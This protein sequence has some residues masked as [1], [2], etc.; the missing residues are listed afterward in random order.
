MAARLDETLISV[1]QQALVEGAKTAKLEKRE[2]FHSGG[3]TDP[4]CAKWIF[5]LKVTSSVL[6]N[7]SE[8]GLS[9]GPVGT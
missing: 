6:R 3:P 1:W 5:S 9:Q 7:R 2:S 4:Y 8:T